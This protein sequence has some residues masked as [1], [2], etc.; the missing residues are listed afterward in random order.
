M[1][2][3]RGEVIFLE[4]ILKLLLLLLLL[5][6][7]GLADEVVDRFLSTHILVFFR[8]DCRVRE[9]VINCYF[10]LLLNEHLFLLLLVVVLRDQRLTV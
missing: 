3:V 8:N 1:I 6:L 5:L 10:L 9:R 2:L 4:F 7:V